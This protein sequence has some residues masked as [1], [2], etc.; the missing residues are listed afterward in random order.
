MIPYVRFIQATILHLIADWLLQNDWMAKN[1]A[2]LRHP[3]GW[4]HGAIHA[5][6]YAQVFTWHTALLIGL[7]H[8]LIDTR[9]PLRSWQKLFGQTS[10]GN[11]GS[12]VMIW[13]DQ[14]V[15]ICILYM[16]AMLSM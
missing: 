8:I 2:N 5:V 11:V 14:V 10:K 12:I 1:K 15:H 4:I 6:L 13:C 16:A 3:A 7:S 9:I